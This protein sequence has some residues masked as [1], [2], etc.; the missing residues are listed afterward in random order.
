MSAR[1]DGDARA[2][3]VSG[4][5]NPVGPDGA[6]EGLEK[7]LH[8]VRDARGFDF[9]GYK[10]STIE[11][12]VRR[13]MQDVGLESIGSYHD[14]LEADVDEFTALFDTLLINLTAFFRDPAAW[15]F[16]EADVLPEII[17]RRGSDLPVRI[18]SAGCATGEEPYSLAMAVANL[19]GVPETARR[20]KIYAT[21]IDLDALGTARAAVYP[22]KALGDVPERYRE[23]YFQPDIHDKGH[24]IIPT[25]RRCVVFGRHD[26]TR[27]PPISRVDLVAC[28]NTL[29]YLN[30]ETK[31]YVLPRLHYALREGGYLFLGR[32][33]M[34]LGGG[35]GRFTPVSLKHRIFVA[36]PHHLPATPS[37]SDFAERRPFDL[38]APVPEL[39]DA[40]QAPLL[41]PA[42]YRPGPV[43]ELLV[44]VDLVVTG[45]NDAARDLLALD[46]HDVGRPL[47]ELPVALRPLDLVTPAHQAIA[48]GSSRD[49]GTARYDTPDGQGLIIEVRI[50]PTLDEQQQVAG[51]GIIFDDVR[52]AARLRESYRQLHEELETAYEEL[53]STNEEL[54]TSNEE[55]QSSYEELETSNEELQST[56]EEL[57]TTNEELRSSNDE[58][59]ST[60]IDLKTTTQAVE[61]LNASLVEANRDLVRY[62]GLHR[63]VMDHFPAA[64]VVL[65]SHLLVE[66]WNS[67]A[68]SMW[69]LE[70]DEVRG[71][72][73]FGLVLGLPLEPL[74][75][76]VRACRAPGAQPAMLEL[77][78]VDPS[79]GT[80]TCRVTV[81]PIGGGPDFSAMVMMQAVERDLP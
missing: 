18:W 49:L 45:A 68:A 27:D 12:R 77:P 51:A 34:V 5:G 40:G 3:R 36:A 28:R 53:Q 43:A 79:G 33:E 59:E 58:L 9:T 74:Q 46:A 64:I 31:A 72:P 39:L 55:L 37:S 50:L 17:S 81:V 56:N 41:S 71:E 10:R 16:L 21:D 6:D 20:V 52:A 15:A 76:P 57:E 19:L 67:A 48:D 11:R 35:T 7:L 44:D 63:L 29:M 8:F 24:A 60:N 14:L 23:L 66:E 65:N 80:F 2:E 1:S 61:L 73:F 70:Q 25:L 30:A 13:R 32:A 62:G 75:A 78:A 54:V 26:L 38:A 22:D 69:G 4:A 47:R 42:D